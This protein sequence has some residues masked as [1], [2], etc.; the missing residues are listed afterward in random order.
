MTRKAAYETGLQITYDKPC[1]GVTAYFGQMI[2][3]NTVIN[4]IMNISFLLVVQDN[5]T[6]LFFMP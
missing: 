4:R 3:S 2:K 1:Y 6:G 5:S